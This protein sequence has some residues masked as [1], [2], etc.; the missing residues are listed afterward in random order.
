MKVAYILPRIQN[1][2]SI[3]LFQNLTSH[4]KCDF[5][6]YYL[7]DDNNELF[8][9][10]KPKKN[11]FLK[12][13]DFKKYDIIHSSGFLPDLYIFFW[14]I[15][16]N[17][18]KVTTV[19]S[20]IDED[21]KYTKGEV[22]SKIISWFWK[23][24]WKKYDKVFV[25]SKDAENYYK[26]LRIK[27][28]AI[29]SGRDVEIDEKF[30]IKNDI[31]KINNLKKKYTIIG[32]N[33]ILTKIKG[34][35]Q[36]LLFLEKNEKYALVVIGDG[37]EKNNLIQLAKEKNVYERCLFLGYRLQAH[38]YIKY[39]DIYAMPSRSEGFG[40]ALIEA[41]AQQKLLLCS[42][43]QI[44]RELFTDEEVS[45]FELENIPDMER[46]IQRLELNKNEYRAKSFNK[47]E[48]E[49]T[50]KKMADRYLKAYREIL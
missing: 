26:N 23:K 2:G 45:F 1:K 12:P 36:L 49:Y 47:Y 25:L 31:K 18:K 40:L 21:L 34:I 7:K 4:I 3:L 41:M 10:N 6:I 24:F 29:Y 20:Y 16:Y 11:S 46:A 37:K 33:A 38:N 43:L 5:D 50:G 9:K 32:T 39:Y 13:I 22:F 27:T 15:F 8:F 44:F 48:R 28:K 19:H 17:F 42:N 30:I 14:S 35:D